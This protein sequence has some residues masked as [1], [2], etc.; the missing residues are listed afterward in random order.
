MIKQG[1]LS[2]SELSDI[3][4]DQN[5]TIQ[6]LIKRIELLESK[7]ETE[8][9]SATFWS[10]LN[11]KNKSAEKAIV[12]NSITKTILSEQEEKKKREKNIIV[13]GIP[14]SN[15]LNELEKNNDDKKIINEIFEEI[16]KG[17]EKPIKIIRLK[18]KKDAKTPPPIIAVLPENCERNKVLLATRELRK[19]VNYT[20]VFINP[21]MTLAERQID[22]QIR[23]ERNKKNLLLLEI[24]PNS[25]FRWCIRRNE[26]IKLNFSKR[27]T[28]K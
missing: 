12:V 11:N 15:N 8:N 9:S 3:I 21:D 19:N 23:K 7:K 2:C 26:V 28:E 25:P 10:N 22:S 4:R 5:E 24:E 6:R 1:K 17:N 20:N 14:E 16:G 18:N 27:N 13:F